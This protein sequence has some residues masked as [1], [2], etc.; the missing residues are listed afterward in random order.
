MFDLGDACPE[1][2]RNILPEIAA[3]SA[4]ALYVAYPTVKHP[5]PGMGET[6]ILSGCN[7]LACVFGFFSVIMCK[8]AVVF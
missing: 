2:P 1:N 5:V 8:E 6:S 4:F 7:C 3:T